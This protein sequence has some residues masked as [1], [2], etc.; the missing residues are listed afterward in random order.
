MENKPASLPVV[1]LG[2]G[3]IGI[4][5]LRVVDSWSVTPKRARHNAIIAF[6]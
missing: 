3:P 2:K 4:P 6:S 5:H 1:P